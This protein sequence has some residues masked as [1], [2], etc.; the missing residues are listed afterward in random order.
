MLV[1]RGCPSSCW[2]RA[3]ATFAI[4]M[5]AAFVA[6][7]RAS[8]QTTIELR[9]QSPL[10]ERFF[11]DPSGPTDAADAAGAP[12]SLTLGDIANIQGPLDAELARVRVGPAFSNR[13]LA[14]GGITISVADVREA[15]QAANINMGRVSIS[16]ST[17]RI[18]VE[19]PPRDPSPR[20]ASRPEP[21]LP[22][23]IDTAG[24][25]TIRTLIAQRLASL[26]QVPID[27]LRLA[28]D[29]ADAELL[30]QLAAT[31]PSSQPRRIDLQPLA[32]ATSSRIPIRVY[33]YEGE[34]M[35]LSRVITTTALIRR[36][37]VLATTVIE[38]GQ[39]IHPSQMEVGPQLV[40]PGAKPSA[41]PGEVAGAITSVRLAPGQV[42]NQADIA[43][44]QIVKRGDIVWVHALAG[45]VMIKA[46]ARAMGSARDGELVEFTLVGSN[47][48]F[49]ARMSGPGR[50][51]KV[52][53]GTDQLAVIDAE[54]GRD[55]PAHGPLA[56]DSRSRGPH[57]LQTKP[58][59]PR[60]TRP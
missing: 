15:L 56:R 23:G 46:E 50:A 29:A 2:Q 36:T 45:S 21:K 8:A 16:G 7:P 13:T 4:A 1:V 35:T 41:D 38:R 40:A 37:T 17:C 59:N 55:H 20:P 12:R 57:T 48:V 51:V 26:Y 5:L 11:S 34:R 27:D 9:G 58:V 42:I 6:A 47:E 52:V 33:A 60:G 10:P 53:R 32:A 31:S 30:D 54:P 28:F 3:A 22:Q 24:P 18:A 39:V 19:S 14:S 44:P 25:P 49:Q 43:Q